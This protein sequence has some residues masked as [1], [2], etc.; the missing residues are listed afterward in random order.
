[1]KTK[2][3]ILIVDDNPIGLETL[4]RDL[5]SLQ[6]NVIKASSGEEA[7]KLITSQDF[8]LAILDVQM[9]HMDGYQ[10]AQHI[11]EIQRAIP[12]PII[13][14]TAKHPDT[15]HQFYGY[16]S[17][18]VDYI[19][20]PYNKEILRSKV[21]IFIELYRRSQEL[22]ENSRKMAKLLDS[23]LQTNQK[24]S[25]EVALR[26]QAE[27]ELRES[28]AKYSAFFQSSID[29]ILLIS[30]DGKTH[31]ANPAACRIL[32]WTEE[33]LCRGG[34]G[35]LVDE[36]DP[37][38][39]DILQQLAIHRYVS[40]E[41][42]FKRK[43]GSS[44]ITD[45]TSRL[46]R[47]SKGD[48]KGCV[49]FRD[50]TERKLS[51]QFREDVECIIRHDIKSPLIGLHGLASLALEDKLNGN[52][53]ELLPGLMHSLRNVINLV[54]SSGKLLSMEHGEYTLQAKWFNLRDVLQDIERSLASLTETRQVRLVWSGILDSKESTQHPLA[55]GEE[56]LIEDLLMNLVRNAVES[57]PKGSEVM[58][59]CHTERDTLRFDI[60]NKGVV[61]ESIR[62][63]FFDKYV[64]AGKFHGTGLGTYSA[65]L[66]AKAHGGHIEFTSTAAT[67]TTV[68]VILPHPHERCVIQPDDRQHPA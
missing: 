41:M 30:P 42:H 47:D 28:E 61:P 19:T 64:T 13:F 8:A 45:M 31:Q 53:R 11:R 25:Q 50:I 46:Y 39:Q 29:G 38:I 37:A 51:E 48:L 20:K 63:R 68:T 49:I 59:S 22:A 66:I 7:L 55:F 33:E 58:I 67:G 15:E 26:M 54:D 17:G 62:D 32:G 14:V 52:F 12:L 24:L 35:I 60:H 43:D 18:A 27:E 36:S 44:V 10:L 40:C 1:M 57:S 9:P 4:W 65:Q 3:N 21:C 56:F 34:R 23:Q 6:V 2:P 5:A 16:Q